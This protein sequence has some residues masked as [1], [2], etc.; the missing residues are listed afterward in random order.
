[1]QDS[2]KHVSKIGI[3]FTTVAIITSLLS[4]CSIVGPHYDGAGTGSGV[5]ASP[6]M[7]QIQSAILNSSVNMESVSVYTTISG[8]AQTLEIVTYMKSELV[9][10]SEVYSVLTGARDNFPEGISELVTISFYSPTGGLI[11]INESLSELGF[12]ETND[13]NP[14]PSLFSIEDLDN[15]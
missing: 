6:A 8:T 2:A 3:V 11:D 10:T 7:T 15:L 13:S 4:G 12:P 9:Q 1:M 14:S 5:E